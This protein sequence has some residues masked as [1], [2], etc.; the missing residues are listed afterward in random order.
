MKLITFQHIMYIIYTQCLVLRSFVL[1]I[2]YFNAPF[3][4]TP[5][6]NLRPLVFGLT[7]FGWFINIYLSPFSSGNTMFYLSLFSLRSLLVAQ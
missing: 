7:L 5:Q 3:H 2:F 1:R 4:F 6:L